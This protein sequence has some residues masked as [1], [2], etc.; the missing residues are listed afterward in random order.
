MSLLQQA[1]WRSSLIAL[2]LCL[3]FRL[4]SQAQSYPP[5]PPANTGTPQGAA[6]GML[7][8]VLPDRTP[9]QPPLATPEKIV[10][11]VALTGNQT[12]SEEKIRR[13]LKARQGEPY[14]PTL[15]R[16][17]VRRLYGTKWFHNVRSSVR[18]VPGGVYL[19]YQLF[20]RPTAQAIKF[21]G[22]RH[23]SDKSLL[24]ESGLKAGDAL[25]AYSLREAQRKIETLYRKKGMAD[26]TV[27]LVEGGRPQDR[28]AVF[29]INEGKLKR[30][31]KVVFEGNSPEVATDGR[32][33]TQIQTKPGILMYL[34][35]GT[36]DDTKL[37]QDIERL[38]AYYR[39]LGY[40]RARISRELEWDKSGQWLTV[41]FVIDEGPRYRVRNV[42]VVGNEKFAS[43][44]L[45]KTLELQPGDFFQMGD[46]RGDERRL[47]D[48]YGSQGYIFADI[49]ANPRFAEEPGILDLVYK[50]KEGEQFRVGQI[51]VHIA[52]ELPHTKRTVVLTRLSLR[53]GDI[54]DIRKIRASERR[55][56]SSSVFETNPANGSPPRIEI[57]PLAETATTSGSGSS[58]PSYRGQSPDRRRVRKAVIDLY[59]PPQR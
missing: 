23:F 56:K 38:T 51:N 2:A 36:F 40:F 6:P 10:L 13:H 55:L 14:S 42:S 59:L 44:D 45:V 39:N 31:Y 19:T 50:V 18:E 22:N 48:L 16:E 46:L 11:G 3:A 54:V 4:P 57:R 53:P 25:N 28:R 30:I 12:V 37:E 8:P 32:L 24:K 52:G 17:D 43:E 41:R 34:F 20:E 1:R 9:P 29:L 58:K 27:Q 33:K 47:R 15:V 49:E 26:T 7:E 35:R 21:V 5:L